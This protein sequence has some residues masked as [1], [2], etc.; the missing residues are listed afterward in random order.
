MKHLKITNSDNETVASNLEVECLK[1]YSTCDSPGRV[2]E[3]CPKYHVKRRFGKIKDSKSTTF[4]CCDQ[5]KTTKLFRDKL[6][7][8]SYAYPD[9]SLKEE[10]IKNVIKKDEQKRIN[11]LIHNLTSINAHNIQEIYDIVPQE[12]L[13]QNLKQQLSV[14]EKQIVESPKEAAK[15]FLR[16]AKHNIHM[17]SEFSI[18]KKMDRANPNLELRKH[19]IR[20]VILNVLHTFFVDLSDKEVFVNIQDYSK[21]IRIDYETIQVAIYH[22][23]E[24]ST[25]YS[26]PKSTIEISFEEIS[27][28]LKIRFRMIS[29]H[30]L[31]EEKDKI[32]SEGYSGINAKK[33]KKQG[34]GIGLWRIRQMLKLNNA[35]LSLVRGAETES[36]LGFDFSQNT[37]IVEFNKN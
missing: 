27:T 25:K 29:L 35:D 33:T 30:I 13:T 22:L 23:V 2:I 19:P 1:C 21:K 17:K 32:F 14:I 12:I 28:S 24:N 26:K 18:Y 10:I 9:L 6:E 8:L 4:L 37:F 36:I 34:E 20:K 7:G 16:I 3:V 5:T 31:E 11:R 15:M